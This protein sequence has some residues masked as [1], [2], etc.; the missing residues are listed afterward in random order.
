MK[1][2]SRFRLEIIYGHIAHHLLQE[3]QQMFDF[4]DF[5]I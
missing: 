4:P 3:L 1:W 2:N 5:L